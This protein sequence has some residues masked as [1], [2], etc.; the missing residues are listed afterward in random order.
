MH[1]PLSKTKTFCGNSAV[2]H[3]EKILFSLWSNARARQMSS[4]ESLDS[5]F[6]RSTVGSK[7]SIECATK[8]RA[9][10]FPA[11]DHDSRNRKEFGELWSPV[12][13]EMPHEF[14]H[15]NSSNARISIEGFSPNFR[16]SVDTLHVILSKRKIPSKTPKPIE[17]D[18]HQSAV[19]VLVLIE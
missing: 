16:L 3:T 5:Y 10:Y 2:S 12:K 18:V 15:K 9:S 19:L 6:R 14:V 11:N 17:Y 13:T 7:E 4:T 8:K 1:A